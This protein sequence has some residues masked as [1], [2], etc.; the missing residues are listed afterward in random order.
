MTFPLFNTYCHQIYFL[1][2]KNKKAEM[3]TVRLS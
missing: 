3:M 2:E 1:G